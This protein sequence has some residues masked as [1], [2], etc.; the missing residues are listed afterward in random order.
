MTWTWP[1]K[2]LRPKTATPH[3]A[4]RTMA[5]SASISGRTQISITDSGA[6]FCD[7]KGFPVVDRQR[8]L[9]WRAV[10]AELE[11]RA[12]PINVPLYNFEVAFSPIAL[13]LD[14][15]TLLTAV[16]HSDSAYFSDGGGYAIDELTDIVTSAAAS[17]RATSIDITV[18]YGPTLQ[19]GMIFEFRHPTKGSRWY[20]VKSYDSDTGILTFRP[21]L[22]EAVSSGDKLRFTNP[23]CQMRLTSDDAMRLTLDTPGL[24]FP[25]VSFSEDL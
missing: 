21:P 8:V 24:G 12:Y 15:E 9:L 1:Y 16:P 2:I 23:L 3:L 14:W 25:D 6:W 20:L 10:Q 13:D 4:E 19:P 17:L 5:G 18:T 22:R 7:Y 11:G